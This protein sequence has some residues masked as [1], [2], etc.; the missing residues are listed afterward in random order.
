MNFN[1]GKTGIAYGFLCIASSVWHRPSGYASAGMPTGLERM[2][3][4]FTEVCN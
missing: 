2:S 3:G 4:V 1:D